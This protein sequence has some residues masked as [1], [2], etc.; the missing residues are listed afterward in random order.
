MS[1]STTI[2]WCLNYLW[3][4]CISPV[5]YLSTAITWF[6]ICINE[7]INCVNKCVYCTVF[8]QCPDSV[9]T[10]L[11]AGPAA[12]GSG[13]TARRPHDDFVGLSDS[14]ASSEDCDLS[15]TALVRL[16]RRVI[17]SVEQHN[18]AQCQWNKLVENA[19]H[20]EDVGWNRS[21]GSHVFVRSLE[22]S[23][24]SIWTCCRCHRLGQLHAVINI[25][26]TSAG[27]MLSSAPCPP[28]D[29][30]VRLMTV[31][32]ITG[33]IIRTA[34]FDTCKGCPQNDIYCVRWDVKPY[35]LTHSCWNY[36]HYTACFSWNVVVSMICQWRTRSWVV[37]R[38]DSA[39]WHSALESS[40]PHL[41]RTTMWS[42]PLI[43]RIISAG[44]EGTCVSLK[45][46]RKFVVELPFSFQSYWIEK[47]VFVLGGTY[48]SGTC[49]LC[50]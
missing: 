42:S 3:R 23:R 25:S 38:A 1:T 45:G 28:I 5:V 18:S 43:H 14:A 15:E 13:S 9:Q 22:I 6:V 24:K 19:V 30:I 49:M 10:S 12:A 33:K 21:S 31:W 48:N 27:L 41:S 17:V 36:H 47:H 39:V 20:L 29:S 50:V 40:Q 34:I 8:R 46:M 4:K 44:I 32:R 7:C 37:C 16:H 26:L 2:L 11:M 35:S